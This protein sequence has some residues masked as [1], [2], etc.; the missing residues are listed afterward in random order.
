[1][2]G[3]MRTL[4]VVLLL[5][6]ATITHAEEPSED[7]AS[8]RAEVSRQA[9]QLLEKQDFARLEQ[10]ASRYRD[11]DRY[12]S[13]GV[14]KL[15]A[16]YVGIGYAFSMSNRDPAYWQGRE[17]LVQ[18]W[19]S[20][21]PRSPSAHLAMAEMLSRQGWSIRG[22]GYA[23]TV[24]E[25]DWAPFKAL[26]Q[27]AVDYLLK[28]KDIASTDPYW[29]ES[30]E[31]RA[32]EQSWDADRFFALHDEGIA[33]YPGYFPLY[34][35]AVRYFAP[36]W[37]GDPAGLEA[38]ARRVMAAAPPQD[39]YMLYARIY[40]VASQR[41]YEDRLFTASKVN[42]PTMKRGFEDVLSRYPS[43]WNLQSFAYFACQANDPVKARELL[44]QIQEPIV[45]AWRDTAN[46][47]RCS[48][49]LDEPNPHAEGP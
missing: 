44:A 2:N 12:F 22:P 43:P 45:G 23:N 20:R 39:Q 41:E 42:W 26:Q 37:G 6:C 7:E 29:Y 35:A 32:I 16:Y 27:Q 34:F 28:H 8:E 15:S 24:K 30:M 36:K 18:A 19:I 31:H 46:Y 40:W 25:E 11:T 10:L 33:R 48:F 38:Y 49:A 3:F 47:F 14:W 9:Q 1:M 17:K 4:L 21:Y 13:S 5:S